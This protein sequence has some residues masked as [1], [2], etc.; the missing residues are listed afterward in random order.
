MEPIVL[1]EK[2]VFRCLSRTILLYVVAAEGIDRTHTVRLYKFH[3]FLAT[4][5]G[6]AT[7]FGLTAPFLLVI[8]GKSKLEMTMPSA[9]T[10]GTAA[11]ALGGLLWFALMAFLTVTE[12][13]KRVPRHL[14][15]AARLR[16]AGRRIEG[17]LLKPNPE[18][19]LDDLRASV[20]EIVDEY[21]TDSVFKFTEAPAPLAK[22]AERRAQALINTFRDAWASSAGISQEEVDGKLRDHQK[23]RF[24][25]IRERAQNPPSES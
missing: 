10:L 15:C 18:V 11:L 20:G 19:G 22:E 6:L 16:A 24:Q 9:W 2:R 12:A 23:D 14:E 13:S 7:S 3:R 5:A 8:A 4:L 25:E 17:A 1:L 21:E